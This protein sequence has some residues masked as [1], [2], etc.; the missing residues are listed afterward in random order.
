LISTGNSSLLAVEA[1]AGANIKGWPIFTYGFD[2]AEQNFKNA[3]IDLY[4]LSNYQNLLNLAV[5][6]VTLLKRRTNLE[7]MERESFYLGYKIKT[8][9]KDEPRKS[10]SYRSKSAHELFDLLTDVKSYEKLMPDSI[11]KFEII[12]KMLL[13]LD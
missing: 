11:A 6:K 2:V 7:R 9:L 12:G 5:A 10:K 13:F 4:T 8:N 1:A 3:N